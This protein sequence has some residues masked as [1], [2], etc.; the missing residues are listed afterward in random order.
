MDKITDYKG[1]EIINTLE[2]KEGKEPLTY[3]DIFVTALNGIIPEEKQSIENKLKCYRLTAKLYKDAD[4]FV[5]LSV[6]DASFIKQQVGKFYTALIY[7]KVCDFL[8]NES[9]K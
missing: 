2:N 5:E 7:G 9:I 1:K 6:E 3:R 8:D 4:V